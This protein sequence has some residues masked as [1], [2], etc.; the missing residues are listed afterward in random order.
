MVLY[1]SQALTHIPILAG[2]PNRDD[3]NEK[4]MLWVLEDILTTGL[5]KITPCR[6]HQV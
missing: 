6:D 4:A 1:A 2:T 3:A 5:I